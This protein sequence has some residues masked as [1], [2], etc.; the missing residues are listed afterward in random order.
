MRGRSVA[1][2][3]ETIR[4]S[5][6]LPPGVFVAIALA[7]LLVIF[8]LATALVTLRRVQSAAG[9]VSHTHAV[10]TALQ[11]VL[12]IAL[13]AETGQRGY[14]LTG[15]VSYLE[16]Y[17]RAR[18][19]IPE[20]L[21]RLHQLTADNQAHQ[22]DLASLQR[23]TSLKLGELQDTVQLRQA[24][25]LAAT[26]RMV[27]SDTGKL[28][29]DQMRAIVA[30]M[31]AREDALL[32]TRSAR[33]EVSYR[34]AVASRVLNGVLSMG[35]LVALLAGLLRW[36]ADRTRALHSAQRFQ[37]TLASIGD[38]VIA[39]DE[40]GRVVHMNAVAQSLTGWSQSDAETRPLD[41]VFVIVNETSRQP[42]LN[43]VTIVLRD[44]TVVGLANHT[45][46]ISK[47][48]RE[49]PIDD[50]AS[51]IRSDDGE[52]LG[53]VL[54]FRDVSEPRR[55]ERE[56]T[57]LL[58][59]EH[60]ARLRADAANRA[61]DQFLAIVSHE[62]RNPLSA[63]Q[64]WAEVLLRGGQL[65]DEQRERA[66]TA[67]YR[68]AKRQG[69]LIDELLDISRMS[70]GKVRLKRTAVDPS[71]MIRSAVEQVLPAATEK[72]LRIATHVTASPLSMHAD[73]ER[74][75]Q[76]LSNLLMNAV[77]FTPSG[78]R[79]E[80]T[81]RAGA[82]HDCE[83]EVADSG[84]GIPTGLLAEIFEPFRQIEEVTTRAHGGLGLGL[85]IVKQL[86]QA[87]GGTVEARS[88]G[89]GRGATFIV[90]LPC[91]TGS[92][93]LQTAEL[94]QLQADAANDPGSR[95]AP[96]LGGITVLIVDDEI[97]TRDLLVAVLGREGATVIAAS[98]AAQALGVLADNDTDVDVLITDVAMPGGDGYDLIRKVRALDDPMRSA[99]PA[100]VLTSFASEQDRQRALAAGFQVHLAKPIVAR[101]LID[102]V[103]E[104]AL[105][106][107]HPTDV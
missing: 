71:E 13:D 79:I 81:L 59:R 40:H 72:G 34:T 83:F 14:L 3:A 5:D 12:S 76:I 19:T 67:V 26:Q 91:A 51:P 46:L 10:K 106:A 17:E 35:A 94:E 90:R 22:A 15:A 93:E 103:A 39:T 54:V 45:L 52:V 96:S 21:D 66:A 69:A 82:D 98:S 18:A 92:D 86:V 104:L 4:W 57:A 20:T 56:R 80:V 32:T 49:I 9:D 61:K 101:S 63:L 24:G 73:A 37:V 85:A 42:V 107:A 74:L 29:M 55:A 1:R 87:H 28:A 75:Q 78:G 43:P 44:R 30:R 7:M 68:N 65:S 33:V 100:I 53:V 6:A 97:D 70:S 58:E 60:A 25:D 77:K 50:S 11:D 31:A 47:D 36:G 105:R 16:P 62:L 99:I 2:R 88:E 8:T 27:D 95:G 41:D 23:A 102:R 38:G 48:G 64:G 89:D 84:C